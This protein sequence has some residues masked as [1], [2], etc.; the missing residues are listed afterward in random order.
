MMRRPRGAQ[1]ELCADRRT[2]DRQ[3]HAAEISRQITLARSG[4]AKAND[5]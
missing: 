4:S 2:R 5:A 3:Q 1:P